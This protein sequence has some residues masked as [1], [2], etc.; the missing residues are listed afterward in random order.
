[1]ISIIIPSRIPDN[2]H[3]TKESIEKTIGVP[4]QLIHYNNIS[5]GLGIIQIFDATIK[6]AIYDNIVFCHD[7][8]IFHCEDWGK[9]V[10][11]L[12][13]K[14]E[15][16]LVGVSGATYKSEFST[17]WVSVDPIYYRS[18]A[19]F[20]DASTLNKENYKDE[21]S[22]VACI[23][24]MFM[25]IRKET[26]SDLNIDKDLSG[27]HLY[28]M[29]LSLKVAEIG[30]KTIVANKIIVQHL[31]EGKFDKNWLLQ[32][33]AW[34]DKNQNKLPIA[35]ENIS[36][37]EKKILK[38]DALKKW[39][40]VR[41]KH[42]FLDFGM[43][44]EFEMLFFTHRSFD[45]TFMKRISKGLAKR[46][47]LNLK[48]SS[49]NL[50]RTLLNNILVKR[51]KNPEFCII[52]NNCWGGD[53][54][55]AFKREYNTPFIGLFINAPCY[56]KLIKNLDFYL[57]CELRFIK[58]SKY[59]IKNITYPVG[60]LNEEIEIHF[61]HY[62]NENEAIQKWKRRISRMPA[63]SKKFIF[64]MDDRDFADESLMI[65]FHKLPFKKKLSFS[66]SKL[67]YSE[68]I[69]LT[70]PEDLILLYTT[71]SLL[72]LSLFLRTGIIKNTKFNINLTK[73]IKY[74]S[75]WA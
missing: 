33:K 21:Y 74:P 22:V 47:Y 54:Y 4:F 27:F 48:S 2:L 44:K 9:E 32:S 24:G 65:E 25:G 19:F 16:G 37:E 12:L 40:L 61:L 31:S 64:K 52:S 10:V 72:D 55:E 63:D 7:D 59:D 75:K 38:V 45:I 35:V 34:H 60:L 30:L 36:D 11:N 53:V 15:I 73:I 69:K 1:M 58:Y 71:Y 43:I 50:K 42:N 8:I 18:S 66:K 49:A 17:S 62:N 56:L 6:S 28:D 70:N 3:R 23:D 26:W 20:K 39:I 13:S 29:E 68:N 46:M 14:A 51:S 5:D 41:T 57:N 67:H